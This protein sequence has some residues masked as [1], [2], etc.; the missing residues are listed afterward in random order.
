MLLRKSTPAD[1]AAIYRLIC[2]LEN[3]ELPQAAFSAIYQSQAGSPQYYHLVCE[4]DGAVGGV[5]TLRFEGQ[6]HHAGRIAEVLEFAV[7]AAWRSRGIGRAMF[8]R[9][10]ALARENGCAQL[11]LATNRLRTDAHRFYRREGMQNSHYKFCL[12]LDGTA[13][14]EEPIER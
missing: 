12:R 3:K 8:A 2:G 4:Q 13:Q 1:E 5:L 10:C 9:A 14:P 7:D 11:E 6:L